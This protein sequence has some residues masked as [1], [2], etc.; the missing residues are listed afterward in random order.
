MG[1]EPLISIVTPSYNQGQFIE[2]TIRSVLEQSYKNVELLVMDGGSTDETLAVLQKFQSDDRFQYVSEAD[3]GQSSAINKGLK[4]ARGDVF[5]W[6]NSDDYLEAGALE[7]V[8]AAFQ[9]PINIFSGRVRK[10]EEPGGRTSGYYELELKRDPECTLALGRFC[11]PSTFWRTEAFRE[12]GGVREEMHCA[13]DYQLWAKYLVKWG[14]EGIEKTAAVLA[15]FREHKDSKSSLLNA[16]CKDEVNGVYLDL[17]EKLR[18]PELLCRVV[19]EQ[20]TRQYRTEWEMS[21]GFHPEKFMAMLA[22][23][24]GRR[25]YYEREYGRA[26]QLVKLSRQLHPMFD[27][28]RFRCKLICKR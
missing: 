25:L 15:H 4:R 13:M 21:Q 6:L 8:A 26:R 19:Q 20:T 1:K 16:R 27:A 10:F 18:A 3:D 2:Q 23:Q 12:M 22:Y 28:W 17:L 5:N 11:Q 14:Q 9:K 24:N 7:K